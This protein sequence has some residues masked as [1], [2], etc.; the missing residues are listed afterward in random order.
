MASVNTPVLLVHSRYQ[1]YG[2]EDTVFDATRMLLEERKHRV[3]TLEFDNTTIPEQQSL[4]GGLSLAIDT[5][6]SKSAA[7]RVFDATR[8]HGARVVH[9]HNTFPLVSPAAYGAARRAGAAVVQRLPNYRLICPSAVLYRNNAICRDCVGRSVPWPGMLHACYRSSRAA[10]AVVSTMLVVHRLLRTW[11]RQ[12]DL[13]VATSDATRQ[14]YLK[15]GFSREQIIVQPDYIDDRPAPDEGQRRG[16]LY[17]GRL[18]PNKGIETMLDS[19]ALLAGQGS[20]PELRIAGGGPLS[21]LV[22][23]HAASNPYIQFDGPRPREDVL[24]EMDG[25]NVLLFP[26]EWL[27]PFGVTILEAYASGLPVIAAPVGAPSELV[28]DGQTGLFFEPGNAADLAAKVAWATT[29][30]DEMAAMGRAARAEYE[31]TY[32]PERN[33]KLLMDVYEHALRRRRTGA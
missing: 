3:A 1:R 5:V 8:E 12:V 25:A 32:T 9:F 18:E 7:A 20:A 2:G 11:Q 16:C 23:Q 6:W 10:T 17:V 33:Y 28:R 4:L 30:P 15:G 24:K 21:D 19:W 27:E 13:F 31:T 14:E 29:H 26:S 22:R